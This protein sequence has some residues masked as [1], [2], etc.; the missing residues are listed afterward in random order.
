MRSS[1]SGLRLVLLGTAGGSATYP[2][3]G[4]P[5]VA[6]HGIASALVVR[7]RVHLVDAG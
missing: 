3:D 7:G 2:A 6:R 4:S 1:G 5:G